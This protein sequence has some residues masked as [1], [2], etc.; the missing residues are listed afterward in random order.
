[1]TSTF[2]H[3]VSRFFTSYLANERGVSQNTLAAYS[4]CMRLLVGYAC[5]RFGVQPEDLTTEVF[6]L[7]FIVDFLD[8]LENQRHNSPTS[9]NQRL[10]AIKTF[11][12]F[13][14][15]T[16]PELMHANERIQA[17]RPKKTEHAPPPSLTDE[18][19]D[20]IIASPDPAELLGARDKAMLQTF[21][22]TGARVQEL[23]DLMIDD[24]RFGPAAS[25]TLTGKGRK[26]R[27][28]PL[29]PETVGLIRHYLQL[30]EEAGIRSDHLFLNNRAKPMTR[31]GIGRR[32]ELHAKA[33]AAHCLSLR[34]RRITPH[35]FRHT[36]ALQLID[37]GSDITVVQEWLGHAD[38]KT[39]SQYVEV[40]IQRKRAALEKVPPPASATPP[41]PPKWRKPD[42]L[43]FLCRLSRKSNYVAPK[44]PGT[45]NPTTGNHRGAT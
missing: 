1:M 39:A 6:S 37:T 44:Q 32:V 43:D 27:V 4:D 15:R 3:L 18:E 31:F 2:S 11:F 19:L 40:S 5:G 9:R 45:A 42:L 23:A 28:V 17:I 22:N 36:T 35:V 24:L 7:D 30:R 16:V 41:E 8:H 21:H 26:R 38:L 20:A 13:L 12:H 29:W 14:A 34:D 25:V 33:A 10:A